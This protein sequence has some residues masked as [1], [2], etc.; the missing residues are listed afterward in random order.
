MKQIKKQIP[1][2]KTLLDDFIKEGMLTEDEE[3]IMRTRTSGWSIVKQSMELNVSTSTVSN[4][5]NRCKEKYDNL[6]NQFPDRFPERIISK[7]EDA[8]D[9]VANTPSDK[10]Q[11]C[12]RCYKCKELDNMSAMDLL[13]CMDDCHFRVVNKL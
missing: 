3:F 2:T 6:R 13:H 12:R 11:L 5:I 1:W 9:T 4:I 10:S 7:V 8:M